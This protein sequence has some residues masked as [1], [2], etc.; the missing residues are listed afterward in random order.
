MTRRWPRPPTG[1]GRSCAAAEKRSGRGLADRRE[2]TAGGRYPGGPRPGVRKRMTERV[3]VGRYRLVG[4]LGRGGMGVVWWAR[5]ETLRR[6]VAVKEV[7]LPG[8]LPEAERADL[9]RRAIRE[10]RASAL[11]DHPGIVTVHDVVVED[12]RPWIVMELVVSRSLAHAA[13]LPPCGGR[14]DRAA[15]AGGA[16][17]GARA[18]VPAPRREADQHPARRRRPGGPHRLRHR[19][20]GG[21]PGAHAHGRLRRL[22]RVRRPRT[23]ARAAGRARLGPVVAGRVAVLR[24]GGPPAVRAGHAA[25]RPSA[26]SSPTRPRHPYARARSH[27]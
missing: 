10:A 7:L 25:W 16:R 14:R 3:L 23:P 12:D 5:D 13:P 1:S 26:R 18:R 9:Y 15:G 11:L 2:A 19:E 20:P 4:P 27:R 21:R 24:R 17:R 6:E 22:T 8:G